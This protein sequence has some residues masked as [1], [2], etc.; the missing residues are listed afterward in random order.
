MLRAMTGLVT[1]R[2]RL[3]CCLNVEKWM[4]GM[5]IY[6]PEQDESKATHPYSGMPDKG[7]NRVLNY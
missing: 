2:S 4:N 7:S 3:S 6:L 5:N 1:P